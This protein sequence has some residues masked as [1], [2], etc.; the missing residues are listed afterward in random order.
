LRPEGYVALVTPESLVV[1]DTGGVRDVNVGPMVYRSSVPIGHIRAIEISEGRAVGHWALVGALVGG[2][3]IGTITFVTLSR[4]VEQGT[5]AAG[6]LV[7]STAGGA[8]AIL[9]GVLGLGVGALVG[10]AAAPERWR[11]VYGPLN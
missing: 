2:V 5:G 8:G 1:V 9:G 3:A 7:A 6:P 4:N 10:A 11:Y